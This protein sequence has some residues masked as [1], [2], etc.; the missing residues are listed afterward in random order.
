VDGEPAVDEA[1]RT[2]AGP[3]RRSSCSPGT[4]R[5]RRLR[6]QRAIYVI[7]GSDVAGQPQD[8]V[9]W[10]VPDTTTGDLGDGWQRLDQT[11]LAQPIA[12]APLAGVGSTVFL[13]SGAG[14][15]GVA[16]STQRAGLSP[17]APFYQLGLFQGLLPG[18]S[19]KGEVGQQLGYAVAFTV[20]IMNF[21]ILVL[22]GLA[23]SHQA[24]AKRSH[25][26]ALRRPAP[27]P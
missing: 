5:R 25:L 20:G 21:A 12:A 17:E 18:L 11:D 22:I 6:G 3:S 14:P 7:G 13:V 16:D 23:Y 26:T 15:D 2:S 1:G 10:V 9:Y 8:S 24:T 4:Q 19:I 27:V